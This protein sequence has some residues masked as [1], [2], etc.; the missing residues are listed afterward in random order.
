MSTHPAV[1]DIR[2]N[3]GELSKAA[4]THQ[5]RAASAIRNLYTSLIA[6]LF[7]SADSVRVVAFTSPAPG[8]GVTWTVRRLASEIYRTTGLRATVVSASDILSGSQSPPVSGSAPD[9]V[10][11]LSS[12]RREFDVVLVDAGSMSA[13]G[14]VIGLSRAADSIIL[15]VEAG[16]TTKQDVRRALAY[17]SAAGGKI[18]GCVFNKEK[19]A[20]PV[21][22]ENLIG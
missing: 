9:P 16:S 18:A 11:A 2:L 20:L 22:L 14:S 10:T 12:L 8:Q 5:P 4:E 13:S 6:Q 7:S 1:L 17:I 15:V 3:C 19:P 21:W